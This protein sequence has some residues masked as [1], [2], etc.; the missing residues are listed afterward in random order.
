MRKLFICFLLISFGCKAQDTLSLQD[1]IQYAWQHNTTIQQSQ[2]NKTQQQANYTHNVAGA[3]P[4]IN[5]S[6]NQN[7]NFGRTIDPATNQF[8]NQQSRTNYFSLQA[9]L[10]LFNGLQRLNQ[11]R[12]AKASE[13]ASN[14][15]IEK[16]KQDIALSVANYYLQILQLQ[17]RVKQIT[18]QLSTSNANYD[19]AKILLNAG[20]INYAKSL[21]SKAQVATDEASLVDAQNQLTQAYANLKQLVNYDIT[22]PLGV[23]VISIDA[24]ED[25]YSDKDLNDALQNRVDKMPAVQQAMFNRNAAQFGYLTAKGSYYPRLAASGSIHSIY[26]SAYRN[27]AYF[28][29]GYQEIGILNF[30]TTQKVYGPKVGTALNPVSFNQ[31]LKNNFGQSVGVSLTIPIFNGYQT[32]YNVQSAKISLETYE[33]SLTD[34]RNKTK[35]D[36]Y[37]AYTNMKMYGKKLNAAQVKMDAQQEIFNQASTS[38]Q[39]GAISFYEYTTQKNTY[40]AAQIDLLEAKYQYIFQTKIFEYYLGKPVDL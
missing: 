31:Q 2:L 37:Q 32:R 22:K 18:A 39:Q 35:N 12:Q 40:N 36:L 38:Y 14:S 30:D 10:V 24:V 6:G 16:A 3:L 7:Y 23:K 1:L 27:V 13:D 4:A 26:S 34:S 15:G 17:E 19:K 25:P 21:E 9:D 5:A 11:I 33:L 8:V 28:Y 29:N 20:A